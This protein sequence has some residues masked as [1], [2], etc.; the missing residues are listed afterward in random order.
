MTKQ[1]E[2][3]TFTRLRITLEGSDPEIWRTFDIDASLSLRDLHDAIQ[4]AMGWRMSHLYAFTDVDPTEASRGLPRIGRAARRWSEPDPFDDGPPSESDEAT[5]ILEAFAF[6]GPLF[7]E[8]DFGDGWTHRIDLIERGAM[9]PH[10]PSVTLVRGE[11]RGPFEDSGGPHGFYEKL[12]ALGDPTHPEHD[13]TARWVRL[14]VGPW[15]PLDPAHFDA[16]VV[17]AELNLRFSPASTGAAVSDMSGLVPAHPTAD[18]L[19]ESS[20]IVE[21]A[22]NLPVPYRVELRAHLER[23]GVFDE[24]PPDAESMDRM[25][26]PFR[27]LIESVGG[28]GLVLTKAGWMPP[29]T[30]LDGMTRLGWRDEWIGEA[31]RE[32]MTWPMRHFR[33]AAQRMGIVRVYKGR[34]MLGAEAKKALTQPELTWRLVT[35][36]LLRGLDDAERDASTLWLLT[37]ADG[38]HSVPG[39]ALAAIGFGLEAIGWRPRDADEFTAR[40]IDALT[41]RVNHVLEDVGAY[42]GQRRRSGLTDDGRAFARAALR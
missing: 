1:T 38:T 3:R 32:D 41:A 25:M 37:I 28:D 40:T 4:L 17:Q 7:Y 26:A 14:T 24:A 6:D 11:N 33:A 30:V 12:D 31:N 18:S 5:T 13:D 36:R 20:P 19:D 15:T 10:E 23:A 22:S 16:D 42:T 34:L 21:L 27:W 35:S 8:Y 39:A 29:A 9:D 2:T